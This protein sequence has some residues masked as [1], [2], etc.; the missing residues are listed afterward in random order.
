MGKRFEVI[1][2]DLA[3]E[4]P[5]ARALWAAEARPKLSIWDYGENGGFSL[6]TVARFKELGQETMV[7]RCS[8]AMGT[9]GL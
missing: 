1:E 3:R 6:K 4:L 5:S 2:G 9:R 7:A 8:Y